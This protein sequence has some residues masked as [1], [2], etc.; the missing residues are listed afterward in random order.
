MQ[1]LTP[2]KRSILRL[3]AKIFDPL[4]FLSPF[5]TSIKMLFQTLCKSKVSWNDELEGYLLD[6]RVRL[7]EDLTL[8]S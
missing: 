2:T 6:I 1:S 8:S 7:T 4:G 3:S 5:V